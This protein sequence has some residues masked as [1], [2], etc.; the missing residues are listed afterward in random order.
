M[1]D[2]RLR[3]L[4]E[5]LYKGGDVK[6]L[7]RD[8]DEMEKK[9]G[10]AG[11]KW[12]ALKGHIAG[13]TA[14]VV[15][16]GV[17]F[18]KTFDLS[19]EGANLLQLRDSFDL[20]NESVLHTPDLL[21]EMKEAS[22][23]TIAETQLMAGVLKLTAGA[24]N[25][26]AQEY[27]RSAP[28]LLEI[29]KAANK[30]NP[31][32][33]DTAFMY[34]SISTGIK[35][36]SPLILDNLGI[37]IKV[38]EANKT[39]AESIGKAVSELTAEEK[40][41]A[42]LNATLIS[43]GQLIEQ[44][45]GSVDAHAD[46]WSQLEVEVKEAIDAKKEWLALGLAPVIKG[47]SNLID[48]LAK[49]HEDLRL[50]QQLGLITT[51]EYIFLEQEI[52][53]VT[54]DHKEEIRDLGE[55]ARAYEQQLASA[56]TLMLQNINT[57]EDSTGAM[58]GLR[59]TTWEYTQAI[60][61]S[62]AAADFYIKNHKSMA[63]ETNAAKGVILD[64]ASAMKAGR[65]AADEMA[66]GVGNLGAISGGLFMDN[67]RNAD[68]ALV[69]LIGKTDGLTINTDALGGAMMRAA[70]AAGADAEELAVLGV[71]T[72]ELTIAQADALLKTVLLEEGISRL[73]GEYNEGL[74]SADDLRNG[75]EALAEEINNMPTSRTVAF[76]SDLSQWEI[77]GGFGGVP[78]AGDVEGGLPGLPPPSNGGGPSP[79]PPSPGPGPPRNLPEGGRGAN[80]VVNVTV[81]GGGNAA[82]TGQIVA[83][84]VAHELG[85]LS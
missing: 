36:A 60:S 72:G 8:L 80:V 5:T 15:A 42:L 66:E 25:E 61:D 47:R 76:I 65:M 49:A 85:R 51:R 57:V 70:A 32:L 82:Q 67:L 12:K 62:A 18:K 19:K 64:A 16:A 53:K 73:A 17:V 4:I 34:D 48:V 27:A 63:V 38:G 26:L 28:Q 39:F 56:D 50:A 69:T 46:A 14:G 81:N 13:L 54:S 43:G 37:I 35:R 84:R 11:E 55:A 52:G 33:G 77:P 2:S 78:T 74:I 9:S 45:G 75:V 3:I 30:L 21:D 22:R 31:T 40:Q 20:L 41:M 58:E 6:S 10:Q 23:G 79:P 44:V 68:D 1:A 29:A 59:N 71:K 24:S 83:N 7:N